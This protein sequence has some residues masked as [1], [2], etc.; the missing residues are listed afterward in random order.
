MRKVSARG[1]TFLTKTIA[2]VES[3]ENQ[4]VGVTY[5]DVFKI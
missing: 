5:T 2:I 4:M 3:A 1:I